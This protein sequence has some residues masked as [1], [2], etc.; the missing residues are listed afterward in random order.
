V[1]STLLVVISGPI[2]SAKSSAAH[3]LAAGFRANGRSAAVIDLDLLNQMIDDGQPMDN[4]ISWRRSM[5][6][7]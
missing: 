1:D 4:P 7:N 3:T 2:A 5:V 6:A